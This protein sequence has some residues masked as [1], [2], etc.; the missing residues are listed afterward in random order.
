MFDRPR[1]A[2]CFERLLRK[3]LQQDLPNATIDDFTL[4]ELPVTIPGVQ[5]RGFR[6]TV[7]VTDGEAGESATIVSDEII[8]WTGR[9]GSSATI[10]AQN[11]APPNDLESEVAS[12]LGKRLRA[13]S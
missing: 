9:F 5:A 7:L 4:G 13:A 6:I 2:T 1:L 8:A 10:T 12:V 3:S 11:A